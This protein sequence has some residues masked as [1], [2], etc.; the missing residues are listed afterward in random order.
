MFQNGEIVLSS[1]ET[2]D[3]D[4]VGFWYPG[5]PSSSTAKIHMILLVRVRIER[6]HGIFNKG[7]SHGDVV[8]LCQFPLRS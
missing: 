4:S 8:P 6:D 2:L 1:G 7:P 3:K 5:Y